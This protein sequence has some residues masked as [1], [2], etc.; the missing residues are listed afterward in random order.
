VDQDRA[1]ALL[2]LAGGALFVVGGLI[3]GAALGCNPPGRLIL[4][5]FIR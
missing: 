1:V 2:W 4:R 5:R 3:I